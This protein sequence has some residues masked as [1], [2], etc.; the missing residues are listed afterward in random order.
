MKSV[1]EHAQAPAGGEPASRSSLTPPAPGMSRASRSFL[2]N[3][4]KEF[5]DLADA[6][7]Q[8]SAILLADARDRD[9]ER[10]SKD[11]AAVHSSSRRLHEVAL[12]FFDMEDDTPGLQDVE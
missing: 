12:S 8:S 10:F 11:L 7:V 2:N 9:Q 3:F 5:F 4:R 1:H 6:I